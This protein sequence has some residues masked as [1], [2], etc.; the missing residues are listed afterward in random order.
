MSTTSTPQSAEV[1]QYSAPDEYT[2]NFYVGHHELNRPLP[3][4][5]NVLRLAQDVGVRVLC[6]I[7]LLLL[8]NAMRLPQDEFMLT[9]SQP[10]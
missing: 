5:E 8:Q 7:L 4:T 2:P 9:Q 6:S 3:V 1:V 10:V